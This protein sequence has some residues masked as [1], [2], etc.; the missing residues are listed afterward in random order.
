MA[1]CSDVGLATG[2]LPPA[3]IALLPILMQSLNIG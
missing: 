3:V 1:D 2:S